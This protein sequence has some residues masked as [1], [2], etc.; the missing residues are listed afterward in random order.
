MKKQLLILVLIMLPLVVS[1]ETVEINGVYYNLITD[2]NVAEVIPNHNEYT[3]NIVIPESVNYNNVTYS[4][5]SIGSGAFATCPGLISITIPNSVTSIGIAA[6][7]G[8]SGLTSIIIPNS[9]TIINSGTFR[10][11]SALTSITIP[12]NVTSI[13]DNAFGYCI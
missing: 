2:G 5:T 3:G 8:C 4:V 10:Y 11:C 12:N 7:S 13:G 9:V 1:A 6:F